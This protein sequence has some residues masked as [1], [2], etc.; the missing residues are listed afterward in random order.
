MPAIVRAFKYATGKRN[1]RY[2][3]RHPLARRNCRPFPPVILVDIQAKNAALGFTSDSQ[4][5]GCANRIFSVQRP[6]PV[7]ESIPRTTWVQGLFPRRNQD[8]S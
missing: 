3:F 6:F 2:L 1:Q 8:K 5:T 4:R 7:C